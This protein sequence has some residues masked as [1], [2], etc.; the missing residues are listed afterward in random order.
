LQSYVEHVGV[1]DGRDYVVKRSDGDD[2]NARWP[3]FFVQV[4]RDAQLD[5]IE[6][7][8]DSLESQ[9]GLRDNELGG[10]RVA[11][12]EVEQILQN[13]FSRFL[14][15]TAQ[16]VGTV[17]ASYCAAFEGTFRAVI[18]RIDEGGQI[19]VHYIDYGNYEMVGRSQLKS[20][21]G[22]PELIRTMAAMAIPCVLSAM[23]RAYMTGTDVCENSELAAAQSQI[24]CDLDHFTLK[25]LRKLPDGVHIV[26]VVQEINV[27]VRN[28]PEHHRDN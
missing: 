6:E 22:Q 11:F 2:G 8:L 23:E 17:C 5:F 26:E 19:E 3:L 14:D 20:L 24:S 1:E 25:F 12:E 18:T 28:D 15:C 10:W 9:C 21:D 16:V 13:R 7:H 4:G 27:S